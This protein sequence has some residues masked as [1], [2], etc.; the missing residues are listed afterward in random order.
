M[1]PPVRCSSSPM[2]RP[3][4]RSTP[5]MGAALRIASTAEIAGPG[6]EKVMRCP[7]PV[8]LTTRPPNESLHLAMD[9]VVE[10]LQGDT[11]SLI[12]LARDLSGGVD[13][14]A[15]HDHREN[16]FTEDHL[17]SPGHKLD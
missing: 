9:D 14:A 8:C 15:E 6:L 11:P 13:N 17:A 10:V 4:R 7:S 1:S 16:S 2:W 3:K 12:A 5:R